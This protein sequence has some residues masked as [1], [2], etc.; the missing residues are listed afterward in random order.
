VEQD[1]WGPLPADEVA[2]AA[3]TALRKAFEVSFGVRHR[4]G[5]F[6]E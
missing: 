3:E 6:C 2:E 4:Q 1:E 5:I